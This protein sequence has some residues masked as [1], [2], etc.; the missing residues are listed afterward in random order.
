MAEQNTSYGVYSG[1][2]GGQPYGQSAGF[3]GW[4][5]R[6]FDP[7]GSEQRFNSAQ[8][9]LDRA[10]NAEQ[11]QISREF[12]SLEAQKARDFDERMSNTAYQRAVADMQKAGLNPYALYGGA[13]PASTPSGYAASSGG[14]ASSGSG[15][16]VGSGR[17]GALGQMLGL[18]VQL[19]A[20]AYSYSAIMNSAKL[21]AAT[22]LEV[23][24]LGAF[25]RS[26]NWHR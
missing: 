15:A 5:E 17:T 9:E 7:S 6:T 24:K 1:G 25:R 21:R 3:G 23:A 10:F 19:A 14:S 26:H 2:V 4:L 13:S 16:R 8:A 12:N 20:S 11:A 18:G 22:S